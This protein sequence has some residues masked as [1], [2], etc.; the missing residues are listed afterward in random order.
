MSASLSPNRMHCIHGNATSLLLL[1]RREQIISVVV[2]DV[3][4][5]IG[6]T[7]TRPHWHHHDLSYGNAST[8]LPSSDCS[9]FSL[10][11]ERCL[12]NQANSSDKGGHAHK[13][14]SQLHDCAHGYPK[15]CSTSHVPME[16]IA[17]L[18]SSALACNLRYGPTLH[19]AVAVVPVWRMSPRGAAM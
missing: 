3:I 9:P 17:L 5:W 4:A 15:G 7:T 16:H 10:S 8:S 12:S 1:A 13:A 19:D 2:V 6:N 11:R 18:A 14:M